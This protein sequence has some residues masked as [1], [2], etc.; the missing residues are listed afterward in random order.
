MN[1]FSIEVT[2]VIEC[3][4]PAVCLIQNGQQIVLHPDQVDLVIKWMKIA[5]DECNGKG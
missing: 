1:A 3:D 4:Y 5:K 2:T